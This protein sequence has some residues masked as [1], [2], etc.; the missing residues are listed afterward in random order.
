MKLQSQPE[1]TA[2]RIAAFDAYAKKAIV[3]DQTFVC[4]S[5]TACR[6]SHRGDFFEGQLH[7]IGMHYDL[8][9]DKVPLR[10]AVVGQEYGNW[11]PKVSLVERHRMIVVETGL[12]KHFKAE[13]G[14]KA[15]NRHMR[16]TT[17]VLRLLLGKDLGVDFN[18][19]FVSLDSKNV[20]IFEAFALTNCLLCSAVAQ[21]ADPRA[22]A[23]AANRIVGAASGKSTPT[24]QRNCT[25]HFRQMLEILEPTVLVAQGKDVARWMATAFDSTEA[26]TETLA[27]ASVGKNRCF[28]AA[29]T[30]PSAHAEYDWGNNERTP[31]LL[32]TITPTVAEIR[33]RIF[34]KR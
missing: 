26:V 3:R 24:M 30:H 10:I 5:Y 23:A 8:L 28:V 21:G 19:E 22:R 17:S 15:R 16:G 34:E 27:V 25:R 2:R 18:G 31:Y 32:G 11:T 29:F 7:H 33:R 4:S 13:G 20:H 1:V 9:M 14:Y 12:G 6:A